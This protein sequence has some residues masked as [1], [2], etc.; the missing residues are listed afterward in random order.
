MGI[1]Y[2]PTTRSWNVTNEK[3]DYRTDFPTNNDTSRETNYPTNNAYHTYGTYWNGS[4]WV[5]GWHTTTDLGAVSFQPYLPTNLPTNLATDLRTDFP[6]DKKKK[7]S[8]GWTVECTGPW[9]R[10]RCSDV[11]QFKWVDDQEA[12]QANRQ[13]NQANHATNVANAQTNAAN[14]QTNLNNETAN[15]DIQKQNER[16]KGLN[17]DQ[18]NLNVNNQALNVENARLNEAARQL[19]QKNLE[20]NTENQKLNTQNTAKNN[21][22]SKTVS[23]ASSTKGGDYVAQRDQLTAQE[24]KNAGLSDAEAQAVVDSVKGNF[25][26]FYQTEKL[27]RWDTG[28]GAQPPYADYLINN[29]GVKPDAVTGTFDPNYYKQNNPELAAAWSQAVAN[30]DIDITERYGENN[31]Y[32]QHYTNI[33]R[34]QGLRGNPEEA[35]AQANSYIEEGPTDAEIQQI[36][37]LQ[38]GVDKDTITQRLLNITEVNN[39]WTKAKQG[40]DYWKNLAKEKY[41]DVNDP[42]EFAVLFRLS[43]RPEDK[44]IALNYNINAGS[45]ITELEQAINDAIGA[46]AEVDIKKFAALNQNILKETITQMKKVKAEQE[47]LGFYKGF[48]GFNE[49]FDINQ[50]LANSILGDTGVGGILSFTSAGKAEEDLL[51]ALGNVTGMRSNVGYNWQQWFDQAIK[52]KYGIDYSIFEPLE[53]KRDIINAFTSDLTKEKVFDATKNE[54]SEDFLKRAGFDSTQGLVD[55]LQKQGTEG[56]TILDVIKGDPGDGAKTTLVPIR[57]RLEADIKTLDEQK[58]RSLALAYTAGDVT[59]AMNIEAEFARNYIDEYLLPRFNT[60][61]SMDEFVEYL[62]VRQEE[63]N[64]FQTQDSYDAV[65]LLGEQYT[66]K[67]LDD[68]KLEGPRA[69]DPNF[70]FNPVTDSY[71]QAR[72]EE[73]KKTVADDWAAAKAGDPYWNAQAYRFGIDINNAAAFARMHFEIKGQGMGFDPAEDIVNA[74]KV[75]DFIYN[76]VL[77]VMEEQ[78]LKGDPIFGQFITPEEFADEMLRGLDPANTP[79][80]WKEILQRYGLQDFAGSIDE[81]KQY[82][83]ETLRTGSAQQIREE[84]KY[85]NDKRQKPTQEILGVTYIERAQDYKDEM[86]KPTT[87]LYAVFQKAGYQGT[88]DEFYTNFFPDL[89]RSEQITLTKAG[90]DEKLEAYGL[91]LSD[92]F[93]S[94]GTIESFFPEYE[95]QA[96]NDAA[97]ESPAEKYVSYFKIGEDDDE[98]E[99]YKSETGQQFLSEFTSMFKG[100]G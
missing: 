78:A 60:A 52:E 30:D 88:E 2:N 79:D 58:D 28:L 37:D 83:I 49:I 62:D 24:L 74:G 8:D 23:L 16:V 67:Y 45:G 27:Q 12:N 77:P 75:K 9:W 91:D 33:G 55:F 43:E 1:A 46:K 38:L 47:M 80:E 99:D 14:A 36:R 93:A 5:T 94:L 97:D 13:K 82:I 48:Q 68:I 98:E 34:G 65:K 53:E 50:T 35:T 15:V 81:L 56:Q 72:Y 44:Q 39:E 84:I 20:T 3:A 59:Q 25:K 19:N 31:F 26:L 11:E 69:F 51:G 57:S 70:Y 40:D 32:W 6:T 64:P 100:L 54:F 42:D 71:N 89:D 7:V 4:A 66:Q 21:L 73:Q 10:R 90:K 63:Q 85:L 95:E 17:T 29:L 92:P 22:Y 86:A 96:K 61:R 76:T 41:L 18:Y 87:Q